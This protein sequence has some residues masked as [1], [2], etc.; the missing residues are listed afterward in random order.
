MEKLIEL[1]NKIFEKLYGGVFGFLYL[2]IYVGSIVFAY[3]L[4]PGM[5]MIHHFISDLGVSPGLAAPIFNAGFIAAG[6]ISIFFY[7]FLTVYLQQAG[8]NEKIRN[9]LIVS[10]FIY[11]ITLTLVGIFPFDRHTYKTIFH[12]MF[13]SIHFFIG[14][15]I[16][17]LGSISMLKSDEFP[18]VQGII[19][20][21]DSIIYIAFLLIYT[22]QRWFF[23]EWLTF[24]TVIFWVFE[25]AIYV[26]YKK[27]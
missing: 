15:T 5:N 1:F 24:F 27:I 21:S 2:I 22:T 14:A 6:I 18:K 26:N 13:A 8:L 7:V 9:F 23:F 3:L 19:A 10:S 25:I 4:T 12:D 20:L 17:M 11:G 16:F